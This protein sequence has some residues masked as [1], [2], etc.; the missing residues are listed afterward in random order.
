[1]SEDR[2][3]GD[4]PHALVEELL[5]KCEEI[6][7]SLITNFEQMRNLKDTIRKVL[8]D[9]GFLRNKATL[10]PQSIPTCCAVDGAYAVEKMLSNDIVAVA[11]VA[12]EGLTPPSEN[13]YWGG[14]NHLAF[15]DTINH[16]V[17]SLPRGVMMAMEIEIAYNA[18][19]E[20][21]ML[22][23]SFTTPL[24]H[25][26]QAINSM[27]SKNSLTDYIDSS[28]YNFLDRYL[29]IASS[30][31]SDKT[32]IYLPKYTT[33]REMKS[34]YETIWP[35]GYDDKAVLTQIMEPGEFVGPINIELPESPWHFSKTP[36]VSDKNKANL[37]FSA[38]NEISV[39]YY[40]PSPQTPSLRI[41][42]NKMT[43]SNENLIAKILN[44]L[45]FQCGFGGIFEPYPLYMAD[46]MVKSLGST[47]PTFRQAT[48][49]QIA[50][51]YEGNL[52]DIYFGMHGYR[53][54]SG[55]N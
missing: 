36:G 18:P 26:N 1:M 54:E 4:L 12:I 34:K 40:K 44:S 19:H 21:V 52:S 35:F 51:E 7:R 29:H 17:S 6:G 8:K 27:K 49:L 24:I 16:D 42:I 11:A 3:F 43:A 14:P 55:R 47:M 37:L 32:W 20:V 45:E 22:D 39:L 13:R 33:K 38:L 15:V 31:R 25:M 48:T 30:N 5:K 9:G 23:G 53:T 10:K 41:E 2:Y 46:R 28:F 50:K